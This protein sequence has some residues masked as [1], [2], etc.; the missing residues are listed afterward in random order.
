MSDVVTMPA[1]SHSSLK[2]S[3]GIASFYLCWILV[4]SHFDGIFPYPF[5]NKLPWPQVC[6]ALAANFR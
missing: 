5:L 4:C 2:L 6:T 3:L 1:C